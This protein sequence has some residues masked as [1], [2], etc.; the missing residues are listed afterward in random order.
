MPRIISIDQTQSTISVDKSQILG[1]GTDICTVSVTLRQK[2]ISQ[3]GQPFSVAGLAADK[4][5]IVVTPSTGVIISQPTGRTSSTGVIQGSFVITSSPTTL[6]I[7]AVALG[8]TLTSTTV[9]VVSTTTTTTSTTTVGGTTT[10]TSTTTV[11][12]STTTT[13][14]TTV[15]GSTGDP[16]DG[17]VDVNIYRLDDGSGTTLVSSGM[18]LQQGMV[19]A[20]TLG[21]F[22]LMVNNTEVPLFVQPLFGRHPDGSYRSV[23]IQFQMALSANQTLPGQLVFGVPGV[24]QG[25]RT[26]I[27]G[28][29]ESAAILPSSPAYI[30]STGVIPLTRSSSQ[31]SGTALAALGQNF[32]TQYLSAAN[33]HPVTPERE[34]AAMDINFYDRVL[35][36]YAQWARTG[37]VRYWRD[38][39]LLARQYVIRANIQGLAPWTFQPDGLF[40]SYLLTGHDASR[41]LLANASFAATFNFFAPQYQYELDGLREGRD[42]QRFMLGALYSAIL[43]DSSTNWLASLDARVTSWLDTQEPYF[44]TGKDGSWFY[45]IT[46]GVYGQSNFMEGLRLTALVTYL[47]LRTMTSERRTLVEQAV[48]AQVDYLWNTEWVPQFKSFKY[49]S[50]QAEGARSLAD[51]NNLIVLGFAYVYHITGN[52][53]YRDRALEIISQAFFPQPDFSVW[54]VGGNGKFFNQQYYSSFRVFYYLNSVRS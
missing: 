12:G 45:R 31:V 44:T 43:E 49:W 11:G 47:E 30:I 34:T 13:S 52:T 28:N 54:W 6:T 51:L 27:A 33:L 26:A 39:S 32:D 23:L 38:A 18:P 37:Q 9:T 46:T 35:S 36:S 10:T 4:V 22:K 15:G 24:R 2:R 21:Q 50:T 41:T 14:T 16:F 20:N 53:V 8:V 42:Q 25:A 19:Y 29:L 1:N 17:T 7:S 48:K 3:T 5:Q 40:L